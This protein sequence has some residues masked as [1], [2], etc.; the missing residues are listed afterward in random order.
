MM[1]DQNK[2]NYYKEQT[3]TWSKNKQNRREYSKMRLFK[4]CLV[5]YFHLIRWGE[6]RQTR[7][8]RKV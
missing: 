2:E 7:G 1:A 5:L 6:W 3:R 8:E 4:L